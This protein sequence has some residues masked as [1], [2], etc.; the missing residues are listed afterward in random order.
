M[1]RL[2]VAGLFVLVG[3]WCS[4]PARA[5]VT[6][7]N[8]DFSN[9]TLGDV[10]GQSGGTVAGVWSA[11]SNWTGTVVNATGYVGGTQVLNGYRW[12]S[13]GSSSLDRGRVALDSSVSLTS[14]ANKIYMAADVNVKSDSTSLQLQLGTGGSEGVV[15]NWGLGLYMLNDK[16]VKF[17][18]ET[19][20]GITRIDS[21]L[22]PVVDSWYRFEFEITP[23]ATAGEGTFS[24][25]SSVQGTAGRV[26]LFEDEAYA[27]ASTEFTTMSVLYPTV[28]TQ[29]DSVLLNNLVVQSDL[30]DFPI[31]PIPEPASALL[32]GVSSLVLGLLRRLR[33]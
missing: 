4:P 21:G 8:V 31:N 22:V 10:K 11:G 29:A 19:T 14:S 1:K 3:V 20:N 7:L 2:T 25:Y 15:A 13:A 33:M 6:H 9:Y 12:S 26:A 30:T 16:T 23:G 17:N 32:L 18:S 28:E 27:L 5:D 24:V